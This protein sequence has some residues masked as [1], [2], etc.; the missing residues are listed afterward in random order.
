M[1][2]L[3]GGLA[4]LLLSGRVSTIYLDLFA[5]ETTRSVL[6]YVDAL[7]KLVASHSPW[8]LNFAGEFVQN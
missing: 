1:Q 7:T 4:L 8:N 5:W 2:Q 3:R 6:P